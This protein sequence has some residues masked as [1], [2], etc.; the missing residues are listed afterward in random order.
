M[1]TYYQIHPSLTRRS[2]TLST[3]RTFLLVMALNPEA[4]KRA[5][6]ELDAVI[7]PDRL[8]SLSDRCSLPY[9]EALV[10]ECYR[11]HPTL[12]LSVVRTYTGEEDDEYKGYRIPKGSLVLA[13]SWCVLRCSRAEAGSAV[14]T[15]GL[16]LPCRAFAHDPQNYP[17]PEAFMPKRYLTGEGKLNHD[18]RDPRTFTFGYGRR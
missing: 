10:M 1:Y 7:G 3:I 17:E 8:P 12:P 2:Q 15:R 4:Q 11:W 9:I 13:N 18:V 14:L 16:V 6:I 5:Q